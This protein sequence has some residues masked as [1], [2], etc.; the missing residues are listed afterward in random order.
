MLRKSILSVTAAVLLSS[1]AAAAVV[2]T[3]ASA[4]GYGYGYGN[5]DGYG[6]YRYEKPRTYRSHNAYQ[7]R[8]PHLRWCYNRYKSYREYD[9][10]FQPHHGPRRLCLSPYE[11]E[12][13]VLFPENQ[14]IAPEVLFNNEAEAADVP[15]LRDEFGN[16]PEGRP[17]SAPS[18]D[19]AGSDDLRD[20]FGNLPETAPAAAPAEAPRE[21]APS[22]PAPLTSAPASEPQAATEAGQSETPAQAPVEPPVSEEAAQPVQKKGTAKSATT[23]SVDGAGTASAETADAREDL[24]PAQAAGDDQPG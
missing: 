18:A 13:L 21:V 7:G 11:D 14:G 19:T 16:L 8:D 4:G 17:Q 22:V 23:A 24:L 1:A 12:R 15:G 6:G 9:N 5:G 2:P 20:A 10:T 3:L